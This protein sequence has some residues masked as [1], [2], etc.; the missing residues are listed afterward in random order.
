MEEYMF[1]RVLSIV[2]A[3]TG[4]KGVLNKNCLYMNNKMIYRYSLDYSIFLQ[5]LI[6][7]NIDTAIS[8][9]SDVILKDCN[10]LDIIA[11]RRNKDLS[12]DDIQ[13]EDV[14][15]D[16]YNRYDKK[17]ELISLLY[18]NIPTRYPDEFIKAYNFLEA[19]PEYDCVLSFKDVEKYNPE[20]MFEYNDEILL[21]KNAPY[22]RQN[23]KRYMIHD[24]HTILFRIE[25][26]IEYMKKRRNDSLYCMFGKK[27]KPMIND[28]LI[29]DIDTYKDLELA[30]LF[31]EG[32]KTYD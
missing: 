2:V 13:I 4:S 18:G 22:R 26:F 30:K 32:R 20:W 15:Y 29:I 23:L 6:G 25:P 16:V 31:F 3:R 27:I 7:D 12:S 19:N 21:D 10:G 24:G 14:I 1:S 9:D 17:Y 11:I 5:N 28:K 8:T